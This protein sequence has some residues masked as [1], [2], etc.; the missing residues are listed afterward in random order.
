[1]DSQSDPLTV[2]EAAAFLRVHPRTVL[3]LLAR[4]ELPGVKVGRQ[5][6]LWR[7]DLEARLHPAGPEVEGARMV[8]QDGEER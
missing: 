5:W 6:R 1:M 8:E 3:R 2:D 4:G 7:A